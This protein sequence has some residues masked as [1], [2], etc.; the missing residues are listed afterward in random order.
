M[1]S[2]E[3]CGGRIFIATVRSRRVS[4]PRNTSPMPPA[5]RGDTISYGP[6]LLPVDRLTIGANYSLKAYSFPNSGDGSI[7]LRASAD[8][9]NR[10]LVTY[11]VSLSCP[12][13]SFLGVRCTLFGFVS[14]PGLVD[15]VG[16]DSVRVSYRH[17]GFGESE[18][19]RIGKSWH[20]FRP[21][22]AT[23]DDAVTIFVYLGRGVAQIGD[24][25]VFDPS[26]AAIDEG[27]VA[28]LA[29]KRDVDSFTFA[30]DF[31]AHFLFGRLRHRRN[32]NVRRRK[33]NLAA[34]FESIQAVGA[35]LGFWGGHR[36]RGSKEARTRTPAHRSNHVLFA[37]R[38]KR[39]R[40]GINRRLGLEGPK[41]FPGVSIVG[42]KF[43]GT[44]SL[45]N[46][47][48]GRREDSAVDG[49]LLFDG[50]A[51]CLRNRVP[52][53]QPSEESFAPFSSF[54]GSLCFGLA[55]R[56]WNID[57]PRERPIAHG[58]PIFDR[59][60]S[61]ATLRRGDQDGVG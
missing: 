17:T 21:V 3:R 54:H 42:R 43:P 31:V 37:I 38:G 29:V 32:F 44:L 40:D 6:S 53:D 25:A 30:N 35:A 4:R 50:P 23:Q 18:L 49:D 14:F 9:A 51:R 52:R 58:P 61:A 15:H 7:P 46:Q 57:K 2:F 11:R 47:V 24:C 34:E 28:P 22:A 8:L 1:G 33:R 48:A 45:K 10:S 55:V 41:F 16:M 13:V 19:R 20:A 12:P 59:P 36:A 5:P 27:R 56:R 60:L 39:N 26:T